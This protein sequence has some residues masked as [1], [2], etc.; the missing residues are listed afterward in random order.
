M[1]AVED[2]LRQSGEE[3]RIGALPGM[4]RASGQSYR[5]TIVR[6]AAERLAQDPAR[7][8]VVRTGSKN[9]RLFRYDPSVAELPIDPSD[10]F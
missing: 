8:V 10:D 6:E 4:L 1:E 2:L 5:D 3:V 7:P 9:A